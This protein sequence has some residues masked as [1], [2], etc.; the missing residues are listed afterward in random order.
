MLSSKENEHNPETFSLRSLFPALSTEVRANAHERDDLELT[1]RLSSDPFSDDVDGRAAVNESDQWTLDPQLQRRHS[2]QLDLGFGNQAIAGSLIDSYRTT[3]RAERRQRKNMQALLGLESYSRHLKFIHS[4]TERDKTTPSAHIPHEDA[5]SEPRRDRYGDALSVFTKC[6]LHTF[7]GLFFFRLGLVY[8]RAG[9]IGGTLMILGLGLITVMTALSLSAIASNGEIIFGGFYYLVSRNLGPRLGASIGIMHSVILAMSVGLFS[10]VIAESFH[11]ELTSQGIW[12]QYLLSIILLVFSFSA[13]ALGLKFNVK[14]EFYFFGCL[15]I[16]LMFIFIGSFVP[17]QDLSSA[18]FLDNRDSKF[19]DSFSYSDILG[20]FLPSFTGFGA[21]TIIVADLKDQGK[22][23]PLGTIA[24]AIICP[25]IYIIMGVIISGAA[26]S[27][28]LNTENLIMVDISLWA[29]LTYTGILVVSVTSIVTMQ[30]I[31]NGILSGIGRDKLFPYSEYLTMKPDWLK[32]PLLPYLFGF[33]VSVIIALSGPVNQ[34]A[35]YV[36]CATLL[37]YAF[38]NFSCFLASSIGSPGWR[39]AFKYFNRWVALFACC[40]CIALMLL[41]NAIAAATAIVIA[42]ILYRLMYSLDVDVNWG[43]AGDEFKFSN[44][45]RALFTLNL[46][47]ESTK[48][49]RPNILVLS[50]EPSERTQLIKLTYYLHKGNGLFS[51]ANIQIEHQDGLSSID[52]L[53]KYNKWQQIRNI[54]VKELKKISKRGIYEQVIAP[55]FLSGCI[56]LLQLS[57]IG[58]LRSN[59]LAMGYR[60]CW[61]EEGV[62]G[63][64]NV[65]RIAFSMYFGVMVFRRWKLF[66]PLKAPFKGNVDIWWLSDDGGLA[67]LIPFLYTRHRDWYNVHLRVMTIS[68]DGKDAAL[69]FG[70]LRKL[71]I[72]AEIVPIAPSM[73]GK[74][75]KFCPSVEIIEEYKHKFPSLSSFDQRKGDTEQFLHIAELIRKNSS[76]STLL[77][78]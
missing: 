37:S 15:I 71:R 45:L 38:I 5:L 58:P 65:L 13:S 16:C 52:Q 32:R 8:G 26:S 22:D 64:V 35:P 7:G 70:L 77:F 33:V 68:K 74:T 43:T 47:N 76:D 40:S 60:E 18:N 55:D 78:M 29:P 24:S 21:G 9:L 23:L 6:V 49:F 19:D 30:E 56:N 75:K 36:S 12:F 67:I 4:S 46:V 62:E 10:S 39:P 57:G 25:L 54:R 50:G 73:D 3:V 53:I 14:I 41:I 27:E 34:V 2:S 66:N 20:I 51:Y 69:V 42:A 11:E 28:Q 44:A 48:T 63:F 72:E 17:P 61:T 59:T 1:R 31:I